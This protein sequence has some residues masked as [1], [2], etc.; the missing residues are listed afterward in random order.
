M[1]VT[2]GTCDGGLVDYFQDKLKLPF[3]KSCHFLLSR[4]EQ[5]VVCCALAMKSYPVL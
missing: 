3:S 1:V 5:K 4:D 2:S